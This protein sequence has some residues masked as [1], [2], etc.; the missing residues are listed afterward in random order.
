MSL[1]DN[2]KGRFT[3][4]A[5]VGDR[6]IPLSPDSLIIPYTGSLPA[7]LVNAAVGLLGQAWSVATA[8]AGALPSDVLPIAKQLI[9]ARANDLSETGIRILMGDAPAKAV[10]DL[11][12]DF[13]GAENADRGF[14]DLRRKSA[15]GLN[16]D[17]A[18]AAVFREAAAASSVIALQQGIAERAT[19]RPGHISVVTS[20]SPVRVMIT[21][22]ANNKI[23]GLTAGD[24]FR[25]IPYADQLRWSAECGVG[26]AECTAV[27]RSTLSLITKIDSPSYRVD[28][29]AEAAAYF[30][31]G[32]VVPDG[33]ETLRQVMFTGISLPAGARAWVTLLPN[34]T[35]DYSLSIDLD[36]DG[37]ADGLPLT[38]NSVIVVP[39]LGPAIAAVTQLAPGFGPGGDKH[40]RNVAV[41]FSERVTKETAQNIANYSVDENAVRV[42]YLQASGRMAI[43]LLRDGIGRY[44]GVGPF[45]QRFLTVSGITD[46]KQ[47]VMDPAS[48][49]LPITPRVTGPA[50]IVRGTV[51]SAQ[52]APVPGALV[53]LLQLVWIDQDYSLEQRY[54]IFSEKPVKADGT[55]QFDYVFQNDD[56]A[57]PFMIETV[58]LETGESSQLTTNVQSDGQQLTIDLFMKARGT[59]TGTVLDAAGS[60]VAN[61]AVLIKTLNDGRTY[62]TTA[63]AS[64]GF[65]FTGLRVG[66]FSLKAVS[67]AL[68]AEGQTMGTLPDDGST[69]VQNVTIYPVSGVK[70]GNVTGKVLESD[71]RTPRGGVV[72]IVNGQ[73]YQ[74]WTR[75][76]ADGTY[77]FTGVYIGQAS[78][79]AR[80]EL[81][82]M[83]AVASG[84]VSENATAVFN[85][86]LKGMGSVEG[87]VQREDGL[88]PAGFTVIADGGS[89][90]RLAVT[91]QLGK[92]RF[93]NLPTG[94]V[95]VRLPDP[96]RPSSN[97]AVRDGHD[98]G[99]GRHD[100]HP[101]LAAVEAAFHG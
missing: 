34:T 61:A 75:T 98:P 63:D 21:D 37:K 86:I 49:T 35:V 38:T 54:V 31:L 3:L 93:D 33:T 40:G 100:G 99:G 28:L 19:S 58:N 87:M 27:N 51:R 80:D 91:D 78:I 8:P 46:L 30:D 42:S 69:A 13:L 79:S 43:L 77:S 89:V 96:R 44:D 94:S 6:N 81:T 11:A 71:G 73:N 7:D 64:G 74:N 68:L 59:V 29:T 4:R 25:E 82:G 22:G 53:R 26:S 47:N 2:L 67:M 90:Q 17:L 56:P 50:A 41:L 18:M 5:G 72:V 45:P 36:N 52:G 88:S 9:T 85:I 65:S 97:L 66:P 55:Y 23:G 24:A 70:T 16:L 10:A 60:A 39:D 62:S 84:Q 92:F 32:I 12:F 101:A 14:D 1:D 57:G 48:V 76:A 15:Q 83:N 20:E 95:T